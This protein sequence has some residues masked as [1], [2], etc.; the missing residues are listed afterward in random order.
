[1]KSKFIAMFMLFLA[2][3]AESAVFNIDDFDSYP[4]GN[5]PGTE[6]G[7]TTT[8]VVDSVPAFYANIE[9]D[10][11][12]PSNKYMTYGGDDVVGDGTAG[13]YRDISYVLD[14]A[15]TGVMTL[16]FDI[17]ATDDDVDNTVGVASSTE[18]DG[19]PADFYSDYG[20]YMR[21]ISNGTLD[22]G[23]VELSI[24]NG[25]SF[26]DDLAYLNIN[27]W[28]HI[29]LVVDTDAQ[30]YDIY[31]DG[32]NLSSGAGFRY[33]ITSV[34]TVLIMGAGTDK[35]NNAGVDNIQIERVYKESNN[36]EPVTGAELVSVD[37]AEMSVPGA[38]VWSAPDDPNYA[39]VLGYNVYM[40][41]N[42]SFV[43]NATTGSTNVS[44]KSL[45]ANGQT[46]AAFAPGEALDY[47]TT[48][49]WRVDAVVRLDTDTVSSVIPGE[50]W[51]FTTS[52]SDY[53]PIA[54]AGSDYISWSN[55]STQ[56]SGTTDDLGEGDVADI[57]V[58]WSIRSYPGD[59][60]N[61]A[62]QMIDR[63]GDS[64]LDSMAEPDLIQDWIGTDARTSTQGDPMVLTISG[65]KPSTT[66]S[67][68]SIHHDVADQTGLFD[69]IVKD[70]AGE[71]SYTNIDISNEAQTPTEFTVSVTTD[72]A[73]SDI[74]FI[75]D[76]QGTAGFFVMNGFVL[77]DGVNSDLKVDFG[78]A[79]TP[80]QSGYEAY[81]AEHEV[82]ESF[83]AQSYTALGTTVTVTP[84][85][86][87]F[88]AG[89]ITLAEVVKTSTDPFNPTVDFI[90][91][92]PG[93]YIIE[94]AVT[95]A[96]GQKGTDTMTVTVA[97]D[98][99]AA[100]QLVSA[101]YNTYDFNHDCLVDVKDFASIAG[102]WLDDIRLTAE[103][104]K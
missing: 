57:D 56:I 58:V 85:W 49:Y 83:S 29:E 70:A 17:I 25:G 62:M 61:T 48:Y 88:N 64:S 97:A 30:T 90:A 89:W 34:D 16:S 102:A 42:E 21:L 54:D 60:L 28:Y 53:T 67:W 15:I 32:E 79:E 66:Y 76:K 5:L 46:S 1:M 65:L 4:L 19:T 84:K 94:L 52:P 93:D 75:F 80:V 103:V 99:C 6:N 59:P 41:P 77:S 96:A 91:D 12:D 10:P 44:F 18:A 50:I 33:A 40:D 45:Q 37:L 3:A 22:D 82:A 2:G 35:I 20:A 43:T 9:T 51:T 26:I 68:T 27:Q 23:L 104:A 86:G 24:R 69:V 78:S 95:D 38:L 101:G 92:Y 11:L 87:P 39:Q 31:V 55:N 8:E 100:K 73:G 98:P 13:N 71:A 7:W 72:A 47:I 14:Q 74:V 63:D 81:T 36:P